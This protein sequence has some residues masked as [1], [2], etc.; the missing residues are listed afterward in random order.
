[1][2]PK[3]QPPAPRREVTLAKPI[4]QNGERYEPGDEDKPRLTERQIVRLTA[5]GH[6]AAPS[7]KNAAKSTAQEG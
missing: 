3:T 4:I 7:A 5:S 6:I 1:M 2:T